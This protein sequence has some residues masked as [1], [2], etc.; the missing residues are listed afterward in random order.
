ML[1]YTKLRNTFGK[2]SQNEKADNLTLYDTLMNAEH[3]YLLQNFFSNETSFSITTVG[4][5]SLTFTG[6]LSAGATS[7]TLSSAWAYWTTTVLITFS[8]G[9]MLLAKVVKDST[10]VTWTAPLPAAV[11]AAI[12]VSIQFYPLPPNYSKLKSLT[13]SVDSLKYTP[14]EILTIQEWNDLNVF[15]YSADIPN[16]FF[17]WPGGDHGG[18]V[19]IWPIPSTTGNIITFDYKFRVP[20]LSIADY[21]TGNVSVATGA[22]AVVGT[23]TSFPITTNQQLESRWIQFAPPNGDNLWYQIYSVNSTTS[24]TLYQAYQGNGITSATANSGSWT[25]GQMPLLMEDFHDMLLYGPLCTY[26]SSINPQPDKV[27]EFREIYDRRLKMLKDY[28][29][30]NT[31]DV[32]LG[33]RPQYLNPNLFV[34]DVGDQ[35]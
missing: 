1:S 35:P 25:I 6:T 5:L 33:R 11:T 18:Q 26:F 8:D 23:G 17:I 21:A 4:T 29:G 13:I 12:S 34:Q 7:G 30:G 27:K 32:N 14:K 19:G 28:A 10:S 16:N 24:L 3:R 20:D 22:V 9:T 31:V 15:P 2:L